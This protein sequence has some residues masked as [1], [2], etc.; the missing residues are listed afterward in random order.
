MAADSSSSSFLPGFDFLKGLAAQAGKGIQGMPGLQSLSGLQQ[1]VTPVLDPDEL[2]KR[3]EELR[4]VHFWLEQNAKLLSAT[5][6]ALEVQKMT[7][8]T[9]RSM[10]VAMPDLKSALSAMGGLASMAGGAARGTQ[11]SAAEPAKEH[12]KGSEKNQDDDAAAQAHGAAD[13][14][15]A[16]KTRQASPDATGAGKDSGTGSEAIDPMAWWGSLTEQFT[17]IASKAL[18]S[19]PDMAGQGK[20]GARAKASPS[21]SG[22]DSRSS[23]AGTKARSGS[24]SGRS[25]RKGTTSRSKRAGGQ[26]E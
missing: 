17:Q 26:A 7:L 20:A 15:K 12:G 21:R 14:K 24:R 6:Q 3:I 11:A 9:L 13:G 1:W 19:A 23:S 8:T 2:D 22:S 10:N 16:R 5:I 25:S 4:T 18:A